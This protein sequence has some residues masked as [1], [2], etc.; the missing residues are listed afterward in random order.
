MLLFA[1][2]ILSS[3]DLQEVQPKRSGHRPPLW[4]PL[5]HSKTCSGLVL[6]DSE[7]A[8]MMSMRRAIEGL[9]VEEIKG[10][11]TSD[12]NLPTRM[13]DFEEA[14]SRVSKSVSASDIEKYEKWMHEFGAT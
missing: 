3:S 5:G 9:S 1:G 13:V 7:D 11:N 12:L 8:S 10:L 6:P 2:R 4:P 14:I